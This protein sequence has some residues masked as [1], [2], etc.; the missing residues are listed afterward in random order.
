MNTDL[1]TLAQQYAPVGDQ[2]EFAWIVTQADL[3]LGSARGCRVGD[4]AAR[5]RPQ[6]DYFNPRTVNL[7]RDILQSD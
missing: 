4:L 1:K 6:G 2:I 5:V 3:R 7:G